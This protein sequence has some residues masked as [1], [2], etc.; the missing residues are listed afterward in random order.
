MA[1]LRGECDS[2]LEAELG[3]MSSEEEKVVNV[4]PPPQ[5]SGSGKGKSGK[6]GRGGVSV[7]SFGGR[8]SK[9]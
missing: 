8:P 1:A 7:A 5:C 3:E 2:D 9:T 6:A 4:E